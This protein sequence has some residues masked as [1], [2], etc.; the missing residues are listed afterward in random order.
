MTVTASGQETLRVRLSFWL[1]FW[2]DGLKR[3]LDRWLVV[4]LLVGIALGFVVPGPLSQA[5]SIAL[6]PLASV[7]IG[8]TFAWAGNAL[9][10]LQTKELQQI[11][12]DERGKR[13]QDWVFTYQGAVLL[14]L[15]VV[16]VW[17]LLALRI[18][19]SLPVLHLA[20]GPVRLGGRTT[21]FFL[22]AL[23]VRECWH[24]VVGTQAMLLAR[25][26]IQRAQKSC[27]KDSTEREPGGTK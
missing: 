17:G 10:L 12:D 16:I 2:R 27:Q 20:P 26:T 1:W 13:F 15:V 7:L 21:V 19:D 14:T 23:A 3:F 9:A 22:S 5:A 25:D 24:V 6:I 8:M 11:G 4:H 18:A